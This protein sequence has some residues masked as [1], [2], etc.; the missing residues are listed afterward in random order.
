MWIFREGI[1]LDDD[2]RKRS[3]HNFIGYT[4]YVRAC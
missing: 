4:S 3:V 2:Q 1:L